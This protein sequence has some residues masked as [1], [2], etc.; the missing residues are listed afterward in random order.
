MRHDPNALP[1][2]PE[3]TGVHAGLGAQ[4]RPRTVH[5]GGPCATDTLSHNSKVATGRRTTWVDLTGVHAGL[6]PRGGPVRYI[7]VDQAERLVDTALPGVL[8]RL[9]ELS[10]TTTL[11]VRAL[12]RPF[13]WPEPTKAVSQEQWMC[14]AWCSHTLQPKGILTCCQGVVAEGA[15]QVLSGI[16]V[17]ILCSGS[18]CGSDVT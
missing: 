14:V 9:H 3:L 8:L 17:C 5:R 1:L 15:W 6:A 7:V 18:S 11:P 10:G 12:L 2:T 16:W 13:S 4:G